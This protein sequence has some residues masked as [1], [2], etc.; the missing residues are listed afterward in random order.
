MGE[1]HGFS[2]AVW[3]R[4]HVRRRYGAT[5]T[6]PVAVVA[7]AEVKTPT[8]QSATT[9][10]ESQYPVSLCRSREAIAAFPRSMRF[11]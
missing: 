6:K 8:A 5:A 1:G 7:I 2:R 10:A 4:K 9:M 11:H 3:G